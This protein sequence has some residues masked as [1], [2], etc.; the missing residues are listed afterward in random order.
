MPEPLVLGWEEWRASRPAKREMLR[1]VGLDS[2]SRRKTVVGTG[3]IRLRRMFNGARV[4]DFQSS[5]I[6][7]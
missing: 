6:K 5:S 1:R 2:P 4:P 3:D 7:Q